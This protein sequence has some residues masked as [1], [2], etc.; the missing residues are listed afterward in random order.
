[1]REIPMRSVFWMLCI[2]F[3]GS[4]PLAWSRPPTKTPP[5]SEKPKNPEKSAPSPTPPA[6]KPPNPAEAI[7]EKM[8]KAM[9]GRDAL[10]AITSLHATGNV[11]AVTRIGNRTARMQLFSMKPAHQR[12]DQYF[13][14]QVFSLTTY[15]G[16]GWLRQN[17]ALLN[18]PRS[19]IEVA[20]AEA[21]RNEVELRYAQEGIQVSQ[22][23]I[24]RVEDVPCYVIVFLDKKGLQTTYY[25]EQ[26]T[27][28]LRKRTYLGPH[29]LGQ[30]QVSISTVQRDYRWLTFGDKKVLIPFV[31]ESYI[32]GN[33]TSTI[34]FQKIEI[35]PSQINK[36]T[37]RLPSPTE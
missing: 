23:G 36:K 11:T 13:G 33:K 37:F 14:A 16:G 12:V 4:S 24:R 25:I 30:G 22:T 6:R 20:E 10:A 35:N 32:G 5:T 19:M 8:V 15:P 26:K 31:L 29:P 2:V 3:L 1:M 21:A 27:F 18:L 7:V 34:Q 28:L 9:G 17:G